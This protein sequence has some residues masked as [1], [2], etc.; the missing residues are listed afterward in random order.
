MTGA[1]RWIAGA[2]ALCLLA[3][4][5]GKKSD[6]PPPAPPVTVSAPLQKEIVDWDEFVGRFEAIQ[7]VEVRP[8]VSGY[9]Q[10]IGFQDGDIVRKGQL[11][12]VIDPRP[13]E[14]ALAQ[15]RADLAGAEAQAANAQAELERAKSLLH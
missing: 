11:L 5:T 13:Y 3:A 10:R 4:C 1:V 2:L 9:V 8:R 15:A 14:A 7:T 12:F 6:G